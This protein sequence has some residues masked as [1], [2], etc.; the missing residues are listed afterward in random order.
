MGTTT[1]VHAAG[2]SVSAAEPRP[3]ALYRLYRLYRASVTE[4]SMLCPR[5]GGA[6]GEHGRAHDHRAAVAP[7]RPA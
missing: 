4:V 6:C 5:E 3:P 7:R 1:A 2:V